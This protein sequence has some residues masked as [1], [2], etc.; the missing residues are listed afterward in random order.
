MTAWSRSS[1][2][3]RRPARSRSPAATRC[4]R[5]CEIISATAS[6]KC[7]HAR[8]CA[9]H[10]RLYWRLIVEDV[11]GRDKP[12]H[13]GETSR[14]LWSIFPR[15]LQSRHRE[16]IP[17][18]L[19]GALVGVVAGV[20]LDPMPAHLMLVQRC[21]EALP[22]VDVLDRLF[23]RGAP[24]VLLPA[25][26]PAGDALTH[27]LAVGVEIDRA[28]LFEGFQRRDRRHQL[29]AVVGGVRLAALQ[30]LFDVAEF[31]DRTPAAGAGIART[32]AIGV[33][34]DRPGRTHATSPE[35]ATP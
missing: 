23:V 3:S 2:S 32:S 24:A 13:D 12:G 29:H 4:W 34:D 11:D 8:P 7:R 26:D 20:A 16:A 33:N 15:L 21:V 5:S 31:Q 30:F 9:G 35:A 22:Q 1:I 27:I 25:I 6:K 19:I 14:R 17:R 28:G 10:P 18:Q